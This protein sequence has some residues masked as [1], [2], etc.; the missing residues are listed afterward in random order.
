ME[1]WKIAASALLLTVV[2]GCTNYTAPGP[3]TKTVTMDQLSGQW[4]ME[5]TLGPIGLLELSADGTCTYRAT[6][7]SA[8]V[9]GSWSLDRSDFSATCGALEVD[10]WL[11][12]RDSGPGGVLI[13]GGDCDPDN[14]VVWGH[15]ASDRAE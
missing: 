4:R 2:A 13:Y 5:S 15:L 12:D 9:S 11:I 1:S 6:E 8:A 3:S 10:G 14:Y 7:D